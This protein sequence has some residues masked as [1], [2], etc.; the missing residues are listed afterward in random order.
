MRMRV[1]ALTALLLLAAGCGGQAAN[2]VAAGTPSA[3]AAPATATLTPSPGATASASPAP[4]ES[5]P[6]VSFNCTRPVPV[7][8][9]LAL[10]TLTGSDRTVVRDVTDPSHGQTICTFTSN[11]EDARFVSATAVGYWVQGGQPETDVYV[12]D[13]SAGTSRLVA[14]IPNGLVGSA[15]AWSPDGATFSYLTLSTAGGLEWHLLSNGTDQLLTSPLA[16]EKIVDTIPDQDDAYLSYSGDGAYLALLQ[17]MSL[18]PSGATYATVEVRRADGT[19]LFYQTDVT[20]AT[21]SSRYLYFFDNAQGIV[22]FWQ[23]DAPQLGGMSIN[24]WVR[25]SSSPDGRYIVYTSLLAQGEHHARLLD[26]Q[27][28]TDEQISPGGRIGAIFLSQGLVW[29][30]GESPCPGQCGLG[31][32]PTTGKTYV[33]DV[34]SKTEALSVITRVY[35]TWPHLGAGRRALA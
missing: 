17:R 2:P 31:G 13:L 1:G 11:L 24:Q 26:L 3:T 8:H 16:P 33:Y 30:A 14:A 15:L 18:D 25:P 32:P 34:A 29:Y 35:D 19:R 10:V 23:P 20:M 4:G 27:A 5:L 28:S 6:A 12:A 22:R 21:W 7:A 9:S